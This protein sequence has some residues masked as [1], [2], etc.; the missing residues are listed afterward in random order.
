MY[1]TNLF[2]CRADLGCSL[3]SSW[4]LGLIPVP[5]DLTLI[6]LCLVVSQQEIVSLYQRFCQLDR[7]GGGFISADE[8]LSVPEFAVNP[9]SQVSLSPI[10]GE[11][12][13]NL[14]VVKVQRLMLLVNLIAYMC[15]DLPIL[16]LLCNV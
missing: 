7:S 12:F 3:F 1:E 14:R 15:V 10:K 6:C 5:F 16:L 9:L 4:G 11:N 13:C 8:F 2:I